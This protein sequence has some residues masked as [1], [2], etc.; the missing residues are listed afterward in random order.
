ML[1]ALASVHT[2][3]AAELCESPESPELGKE[4]LTSSLLKEATSGVQMMSPPLPVTLFYSYH[5]SFLLKRL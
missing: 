4:R 5:L 1:P 3:P 2:L